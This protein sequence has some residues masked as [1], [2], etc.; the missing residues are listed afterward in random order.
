MCVYKSFGPNRKKAIFV[1]EMCAASLTYM[2]FI[3]VTKF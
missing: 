3:F 2:S 1:I